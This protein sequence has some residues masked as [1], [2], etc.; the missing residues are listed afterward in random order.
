MQNEK[1]NQNIFFDEPTDIAL[2]STTKKGSKT[3]NTKRTAPKKTSSR[4]KDHFGVV[5][6]APVTLTFSLLCI[7]VILLKQKLQNLPVIFTAPACQASEFAFNWKDPIHY[8]RLVLHVFGHTDWNQLTGNLAFILLLGPALEDKFGSGLLAL[9]MII[10]AFISGVINACF[11]PSVLMGASGIVFMMI[12]LSSVTAADKTK[13]PLTF[14]LICLIYVGKEFLIHE[15]A[16]TAAVMT[17]AHIAGGICGSILGFLGMGSS[18]KR[19]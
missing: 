6:N 3:T 4:K 13:I 2:P 10:T 11:I 5:Y 1:D 17:V 8:A 15:E 7:A 12:L 19:S 14:I 16:G 18:K 9:M